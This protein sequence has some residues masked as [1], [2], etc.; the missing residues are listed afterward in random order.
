MKTEFMI[1]SPLG[2]RKPISFDTRILEWMPCRHMHLFIENFFLAS[3]RFLTRVV[4][5][6][7]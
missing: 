3:V 2:A 7:R 6:A 5:L 1:R 4:G